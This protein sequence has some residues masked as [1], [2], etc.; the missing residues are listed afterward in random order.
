ME[1]IMPVEN[2]ELTFWKQ[3][4]Y[5][6]WPWLG[7]FDTCQKAFLTFSPVPISSRRSE[8]TEFCTVKGEWEE[9]YRSKVIGK[10]CMDVGCGMDGMIPFWKDA[11]RRILVDP[12]VDEY[13]K[14]IDEYMI[15]KNKNGINWLK[16]CEFKP[17]SALDQKMDDMVGKVD[18]I[19]VF[20][21]ALDHYNGSQLSFL[22]R[23][24]SFLAPR[25][26]LFFWSE[27]THSSVDP[28]HH[29]CDLTKESIQVVLKELDFEVLK[30][31]TAVH[32]PG[33]ILGT[34]FGCIAV[35]REN[36]G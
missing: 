13:S 31:V 9:I 16:E 17:Y 19:L 36:R 30:P 15:S 7:G 10:T 35:K 33:Y 5:G 21:N 32:G 27:L 4:L 34:D 3:W 18:G 11:H 29:N 24:L 28:G 1:N 6:P 2:P 14:A 8:I 25:G 20:R 23:V 12:L 26:L 22:K